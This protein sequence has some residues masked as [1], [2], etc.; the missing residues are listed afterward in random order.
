MA[1]TDE[2]LD[3]LKDYARQLGRDGVLND[4]TDIDVLLAVMDMAEGDNMRTEDEFN[5]H[6][7]I[8]DIPDAKD[9]RDIVRQWE[10]GDRALKGAMHDKLR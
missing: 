2:Q 3:Q 7:T 6:I 9:L 5:A 10:V 8:D 4:P 1:V